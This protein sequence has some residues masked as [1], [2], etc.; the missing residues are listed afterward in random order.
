M[1]HRQSPLTVASTEMRAIAHREVIADPNQ[2]T[3]MIHFVGTKNKT[4]VGT[5][6]AKAG[7]PRG[8]RGK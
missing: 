6:R 1:T 4:I 2:I 8:K 7:N 5:D 3:A